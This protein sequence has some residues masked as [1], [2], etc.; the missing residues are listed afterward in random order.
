MPRALQSV[1]LSFGLVTI[2]VKLYSAASS[3]SVSFHMLHQKDG[4]RIKQHLYCQAEEKEVSRDEI[5]KGYE[6]S[7]GHYVEIRD[8]ELEALEETANRN[9]EIHEFVPLDVI[10]PV[11]FEKTYYLGPDKGGDKPYRLLVETMRQRNCGAIAKFVMRGKE[12]LVLVRPVDDQHLVL[13]VLYYAD[14]VKNLADI[15]VPKIPLREGELKLADQ[16][17]DSLFHKTWEPEKYHDTYREKVLALIQTKAE[18]HEVVAPPKAADTGGVLDLMDAL[19]QSLARSGKAE[20]EKRP[21][22]VGRKESPRMR[23][24]G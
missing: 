3:K 10:D 2:P 12:N 23:K 17:V 1:S 6:V 16:L 14:E 24:A 22:K 20:K 7:N 13:D 15:D 9:V 19:K 8:E 5:I 4:S 21:A 11:Y 18:G